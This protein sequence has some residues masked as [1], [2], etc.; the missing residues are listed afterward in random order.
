MGLSK[1]PS[2][3]KPLNGAFEIHIHKYK[4]YKQP[5]EPCRKYGLYKYTT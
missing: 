2:L 3:G 1:T 4:L 5:E